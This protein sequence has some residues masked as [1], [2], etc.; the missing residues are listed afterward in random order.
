MSPGFKYL[1][2]E[3]EEERSDVYLLAVNTCNHG[4]LHKHPQGILSKLLYHKTG[5]R[6]FSHTATWASIS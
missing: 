2:S 6:I 4:N 1:L 5:C 3:T